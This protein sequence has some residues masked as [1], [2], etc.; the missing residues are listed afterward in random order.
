MKNGNLNEASNYYSVLPIFCYATSVDK[1][2]RITDG[3]IIR[4]GVLGANNSR[5]N[6]SCSHNLI[7][8]TFNCIVKSYYRIVRKIW[9]VRRLVYGS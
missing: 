1:N 6:R 7:L 9:F 5:H 4:L 3:D 2:M 8:C